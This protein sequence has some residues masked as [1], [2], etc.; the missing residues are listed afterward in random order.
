M[1][2]RWFHAQNE[3][4]VRYESLIEKSKYWI[5]GKPES[6]KIGKGY[7]YL[8][9]KEVYYTDYEAQLDWNK[10]IDTFD[11][12][13]F[14]F[15]EDKKDQLKSWNYCIHTGNWS[16]PYNYNKNIPINIDKQNYFFELKDRFTN[17]RFK[18][19]N[20]GLIIS[21]EDLYIR[22][23]ITILKEYLGLSDKLK[24]PFPEG[25]RL[26]HNKIKNTELI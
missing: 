11:K 20:K 19:K 2:G 24:R 17:F 18:N 6:Y 14:L 4:D 13:V 23:K 21:Y 25:Q 22:N 9:L 26:R 7:K 10:F 16:N 12:V 1:L 15:R 3:F 5:D 8:V